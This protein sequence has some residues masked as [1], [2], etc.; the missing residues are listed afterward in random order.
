MQKRWESL[1]RQG[2]RIF[3]VGDLMLNQILRRT[4]FQI[5]GLVATMVRRV[6]GISSPLQA[7]LEAACGVLLAREIGAAEVELEGDTAMVLSAINMLVND[8]TSSMGHII[9][10]TR[11][12][13]RL[14]PKQEFYIPEERPVAHR[15]ARLGLSSE[16]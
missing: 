10:D 16:Q 8:D 11:H 3:V 7:K 12:F 5:K 1:L 6:E 15:L 14:I 9:N 2:R 13:L 4:R